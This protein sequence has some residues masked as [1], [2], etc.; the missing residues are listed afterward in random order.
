MEDVELAPKKDAGTVG[1]KIQLSVNYYRV[2][3]A[4]NVTVTHFDFDIKEDL[5]TLG[6]VIWKISRS[7][8]IHVF[9]ADFFLNENLRKITFFKIYIIDYRLP[10]RFLLDF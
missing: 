10:G 1:K 9:C 5:A 3:I 7:S 2:V 4:N 8:L 6:K